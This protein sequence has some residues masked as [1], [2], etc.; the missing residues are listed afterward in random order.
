MYVYNYKGTNFEGLTMTWDIHNKVVISLNATKQYVFSCYPYT[1]ST[2]NWSQKTNINIAEIN[3]WN[4]ISCAV[5]TTEVKLFH[6]FTDTVQTVSTAIAAPVIDYS[7]LVL[8]TSTLI[9]ED[10]SKLEYGLLFLQ[11]IRLWHEAISSDVNGLSKTNI[12]TLGLFKNLKHLFNPT[13]N[14]A[15]GTQQE[16]KDLLITPSADCPPRG[17]NIDITYIKD[18]NTVGLNVVDETKY[19]LLGL[20]QETG[21]FV[22]PSSGQSGVTPNSNYIHYNINYIL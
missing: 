19:S 8:N 7:K 6:A 22:D 14:S 17:D 3:K 15:D 10:T 5:D 13:F 16:L 11:Q 9:I 1:D 2:D 21:Q 20:T 18:A 4:F 12:V